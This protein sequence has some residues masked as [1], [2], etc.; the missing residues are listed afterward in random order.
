MFRVTVHCV[1]SYATNINY[2]QAVLSWGEW[3]EDYVGLCILS[4]PS[5]L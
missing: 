1:D 5:N 3:W 4:Q 2:T